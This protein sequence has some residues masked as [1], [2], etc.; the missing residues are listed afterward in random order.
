MRIALLGNTQAQAERLS[1]LLTFEHEIIKVPPASA[2]DAAPLEVDAAITIRF[3]TED[4]RRVH[5][6]ALRC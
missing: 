3:T 5:C 2:A 1:R 4:A 6:R